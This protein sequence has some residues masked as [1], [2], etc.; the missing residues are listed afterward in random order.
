MGFP[1]KNMIYTLQ[2]KVLGFCCCSF[3][4]SDFR[5]TE[6]ERA[7]IGSCGHTSPDSS[8]SP[9]LHIFLSFEEPF[10][11]NRMPLPLWALM[12][13]LGRPLGRH[14]RSLLLVKS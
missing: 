9:C 12:L 13:L 10:W 2:W 3:A 14:A 6:K 8:R 5:G 11:K 7:P 4:I 1:C